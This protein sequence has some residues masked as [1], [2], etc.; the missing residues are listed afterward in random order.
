MSR[1]RPAQGPALPQ[2]NRFRAA[3]RHSGNHV[4]EPSPTVGARAVEMDRWRF[5]WVAVCAGIGLMLLAG[6]MTDASVAPMAAAVSSSGRAD[7]DACHPGDVKTWK[8]TYH[9]KA[10]RA[11]HGDLLKEAAQYWTVDSK[12]NPGPS[13]GN[14]DGKLYGLDDVELVVGT[15]WK[16][17]FLVKNPLTGH[18]QFLDKQWNSYTGVWEGYANRDDWDAGCANCHD[19]GGKPARL[20]A[21]SPAADR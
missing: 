10:A 8:E 7:C 14:L 3:P 19:E 12:G 15:R 21:D 1:G 16:Q 11:P 17:R 13:R 4:A 2:V 20:V 18:H 5:R 9:A 6:C